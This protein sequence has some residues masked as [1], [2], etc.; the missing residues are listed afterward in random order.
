MEKLERLTKKSW[1]D[2]KFDPSVMDRERLMRLWTLENFIDNGELIP[3]LCPVGGSIYTIEWAED[4]ATPVGVI[5]WTI[6]HI[7]IVGNQPDQVEYIAKR[8]KDISDEHCFGYMT[9]YQTF[10][11]PF[12]NDTWFLTSS[13]AEAAIINISNERQLNKLRDELDDTRRA[14]ASA[15]EAYDRAFKALQN[16]QAEID[17]LKEKINEQ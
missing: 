1:H 9:A 2:A 17:T 14:Y 3:L 13:E 12:F 11:G 7:N 15:Q 5:E 4:D 6:D 16:K 8:I 10:T